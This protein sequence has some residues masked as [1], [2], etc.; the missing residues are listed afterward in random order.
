[1]HDLIPYDSQAPLEVAAPFANQAARQGR[2][3]KYKRELSPETLR[4]HKADIALFR[5]YLEV[6]HIP[7]GDMLNNIEAWKGVSWG[8]VEGFREWQ[9]QQKYAM[10]SVNVRLATIK[11]YAR[12]AYE[13]GIILDEDYRLI[14]SVRGFYGKQARNVD[15]KREEIRIGPKKGDPTKVSLSHMQALKSLLEKDMSY[16]GLRDYLL[17]CLLGYQGLRCGEVASLLATNVD[18]RESLIVFYRRKVHTVQQHHMHATTLQVMRRYLEVFNP[19]DKLFTGID[20]AEW[21]DSQGKLHKGHRAEQGLSTRAINERIQYLGKKVGLDHL[22]PHDLRH[23]WTSDAFRQK[24]PI[25]VVQEA[26]GWR[27]YAMP[28]H[29]RKSSG[30]A[31]EGIKQSQ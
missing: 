23:Y 21:T 4:R 10:G 24:T 2:L 19:Q 28:L 25:D 3:D 11:K 22:S 17:V 9:L 1:M 29:Y 6:A 13:S 7:T 15:E 18:L 20:R 14:Q 26:G 30:I 8:I 31:N 27:S 16:F 12:I 5:Q